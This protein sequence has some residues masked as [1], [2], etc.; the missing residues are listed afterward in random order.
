MQNPLKADPPTF[1]V[2]LPTTESRGTEEKEWKPHYRL[3]NVARLAST[4]AAELIKRKGWG[5]RP[6]LI[7][8]CQYTGL[9]ESNMYSNKRLC[10]KRLF[11]IG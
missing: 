11:G 2:C 10:S 8:H 7:C 9:L 5:R 1:P 4:P 3:S 6:G